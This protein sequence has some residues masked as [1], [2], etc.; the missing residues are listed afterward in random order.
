MTLDPTQILLA[1]ALLH[2]LAVAMLLAVDLVR[3]RRAIEANAAKR[4]PL[5]ARRKTPAPRARPRAEEQLL[6]SLNRWRDGTASGRNLPGPAGRCR[7]GERPSLNR[8]IA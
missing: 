5:S 4:A 6:Q 3:S 8:S 1:F 2:G 7:S